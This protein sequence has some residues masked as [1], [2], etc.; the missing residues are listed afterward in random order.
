MGVSI[1]NY[2]EAK[3]Y[4]FPS[5]LGARTLTGDERQG[6]FQPLAINYNDAVIMPMGV[7]R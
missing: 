3:V 4:T 5:E 1:I 7:Y 2:I 6:C